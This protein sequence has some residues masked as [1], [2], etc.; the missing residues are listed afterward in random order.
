MQLTVLDNRNL[1]LKGR[2]KA[3]RGSSQLCLFRERLVLDLSCAAVEQVQPSC[4]LD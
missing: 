3:K 2:L 4:L 1:N